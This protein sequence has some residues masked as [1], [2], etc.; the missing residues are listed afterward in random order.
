MKAN[1]PILTFDAA[2]ATED[3]LWVAGEAE[4]HSAQQLRISDF[5]ET[6]W[7]YPETIVSVTS[8]GAMIKVFLEVVGH[9]N[10]NFNLTTGQIMPVLISA[11]RLK[12]S[13]DISGVTPPTTVKTCP[14][15]GPA[16]ENMEKQ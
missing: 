10:P 6:V 7:K 5:L 1:F 8:H 12:G 15:C 16:Q 13:K 14:L 2:M 11:E 4:S 3:T 9:P